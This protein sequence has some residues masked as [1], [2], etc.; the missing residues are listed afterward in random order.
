MIDPTL[1]IIV[2]TDLNMSSAKIAAQCVHATIRM[3]EKV[4]LFKYDDPTQLPRVIIKK[5]KSLEGLLNVYDKAQN[6]GVPTSMQIDAGLNEVPENT[7]TVISIGPD[8]SEKCDPIVKRLRNL[9]D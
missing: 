6:S 1:Y 3:R 2:R 9:T 7:P 8:S 4:L 5:V